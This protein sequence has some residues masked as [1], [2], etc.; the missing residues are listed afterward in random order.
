[1]T[2]SRPPKEST[3][4]RRQ[5][6]TTPQARENQLIALAYDRAE[7]QIVEGTASAVVL[8]HFIK[9]GSTRGRLEERRIEVDI[10][11]ADAKIQT[12]AS[13]ARVEELYT[14]AMAAMRSYQ[15]AD[16]YDGDDSYDG[17]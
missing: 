8:S 17:Y 2:Q 1:M 12:M 16:D 5:P 6:A 14:E 4:K 7:Q 3:P 15:G 13:M 11:L 9:A 10:E